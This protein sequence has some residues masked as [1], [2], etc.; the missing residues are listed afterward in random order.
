MNSFNQYDPYAMFKQQGQMMD[1]G[2]SQ[3][4]VMQNLGGQQ[5]MQQ[6]NMSNMGM[7]ANQA[8]DTKGTQQVKFDNKAMADALRQ[9]SMPA[10]VDMAFNSQATPEL[11]QQVDAMGS[12]TWNPFS[13]Y[14]TGRNGWGNYGE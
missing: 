4:P 13:D 14:N 2:G 1:V 10:R 9:S 8:L 5:S 12:S 7:L 11:Q 6:Q 3:G